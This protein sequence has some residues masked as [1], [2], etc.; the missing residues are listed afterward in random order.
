MSPVPSR[1]TDEDLEQVDECPA[2]SPRCEEDAM[3]AIG[4]THDDKSITE[5]AFNDHFVSMIQK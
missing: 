3:A 2:A 5:A 4:I 1:L